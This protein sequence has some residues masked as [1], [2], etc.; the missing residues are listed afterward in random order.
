MPEVHSPYT[1]TGSN[2]SLEA[3]NL[4]S[5]L[6][7]STYAVVGAEARQFSISHYIDENDSDSLYFDLECDGQLHHYHSLPTTQIV[8]DSIGAQEN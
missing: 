5:G 1:E 6:Y 8:E 3:E 2:V 4:C 7:V